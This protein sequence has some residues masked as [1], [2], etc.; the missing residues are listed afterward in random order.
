MEVI[1]KLIG[2]GKSR[3]VYEYLPDPNWVVKIN[4]ENV[5]YFGIE[6][7]HDANADEYFWY[8]E[9]KKIG[10]HTWLA[11]CKYS[12]DLFLMRRAGNLTP[13]K[14]AIPMWF[15]DTN[16]DNWG[17][18]NNKLVSIDYAWFHIKKQPTWYIDNGEVKRREVSLDLFASLKRKEIIV[19]E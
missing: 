6:A 16:A 17:L 5:N 4:K 15:K 19:E 3:L 13:G 12:N 11:E 18:I 10:L 8:N 2:E 9:L 14:Y 1:G 7:V